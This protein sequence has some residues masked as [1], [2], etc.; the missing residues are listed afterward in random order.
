MERTEEDITITFHGYEAGIA[1]RALLNWHAEFYTK[2]MLKHGPNDPV[3]LSAL[4]SVEQM[5]ELEAEIHRQLT[6]IREG[7]GQ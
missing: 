1:A 5:V 3:A 4:E 2:Q 7:Q 6:E